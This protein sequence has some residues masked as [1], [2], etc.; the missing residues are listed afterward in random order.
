MNKF[1]N[2]KKDQGSTYAVTTRVVMTAQLGRGQRQLWVVAK[3]M[4]FKR[5]PLCATCTGMGNDEM[6]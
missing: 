3:V 6:M 4:S 2:L 1:G 5:T